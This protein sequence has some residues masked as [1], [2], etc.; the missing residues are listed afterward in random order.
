MRSKRTKRILSLVLAAS[1]VFTQVG[2]SVYAE[3][4][5]SSTEGL[6]EHHPKHTA[7]CGY[8]AGEE[9]KTCSHKHTRGLLSTGGAVCPSAHQRLLRRRGGD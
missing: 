3:G 6:C 4:S 2:A 8:E 7:E 1:L 9:G 5:K